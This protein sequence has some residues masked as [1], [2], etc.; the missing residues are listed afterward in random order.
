M[1][2]IK[3]DIKNLLSVPDQQL[4][5][6]LEHPAHCPES[7]YPQRKLETYKYHCLIRLI[8]LD[9]KHSIGRQQMEQEIHI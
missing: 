5:L 1:D 2:D 8:I 6:G 9:Q 7:D 4:F 3:W